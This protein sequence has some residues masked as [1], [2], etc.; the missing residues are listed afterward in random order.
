MDIDSSNGSSLSPE[1]TIKDEYGNDVVVT[2]VV[3]QGVYCG[4][5]FAGTSSGSSGIYYLDTSSGQKSADGYVFKLLYKHGDANDNSSIIHSMSYCSNPSKL[6]F[7]T[8]FE[9]YECDIQDDAISNVA[10]MQSVLGKDE[11]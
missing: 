10:Y 4:T 5:I 3:K 9:V 6:T 8:T 1:T 11:N 2:A 7:A